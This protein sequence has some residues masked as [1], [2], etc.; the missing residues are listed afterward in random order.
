MTVE[1]AVMMEKK[2][3]SKVESLQKQLNELT[4]TVLPLLKDLTVLRSAAEK[5][6]GDEL[7]TIPLKEF[8]KETQE[9]LKQRWNQK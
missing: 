9:Q 3:A 8:S 1:A 5:Q 7:T 6:N 2:E 4:S